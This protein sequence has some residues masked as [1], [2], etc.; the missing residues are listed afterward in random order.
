[1]P[2]QS[3]K[4]EYN[5]FVKGLITEA[6]P[7]NFPENASQDE[8]NFDLHRTGTRSRR[9]GMAY[10]PGYSLVNSLVTANSVRA[11][12]PTTFQW[13]NTGGD[14]GLTILV[15]QFENNLNFFNQQ[16]EPLA[17]SGYLATITLSGFPS[18]VQYSFTSVDGTLVVAAGIDTIC[19]VNYTGSAFVSSYERIAVRDV[20]GIEEVNEPSYETDSS[21]RGGIDSYHYYNLQNQ[22]WGIPRKRF[23]GVVVD[24]AWSYFADGGKGVWP[25]NS[26]AVW[27]GLQFKPIE[28]SA[29]PYEHLFPRLF[30]DVFGAKVVSAKG[31]YIIDLLRRGTSRV[32][33]LE[34]NYTKFPEL[35]YNSIS[36]PADYTSG[37]AT[38][39][40]DFAGRVFYGGFNGV[41]TDGD[42]RSPNL[43]NY[44]FFSQLIKNKKDFTKCYQEGDPTSRDSS[45]LVDTDGGFVR[46]SGMDRLIGMVSLSTHLIVIANN[47]VWAISGGSDFGFTPTNYKV[48]KLS[49]FGGVGRFSI[50]ENLGRALFWGEDGIF[51]VAK[52]QFGEF[53]VASITE[54]TIQT[55]YDSIDSKAKQE[56]VGVYDAFGKK[57]RWIYKLNDAFTASS[58]TWELVLDT[59]LNAFYKQRIYNSPN[60]TTEVFSV[61][62]TLGIKTDG[63]VNNILSGTD[64]VVSGFSE[65]VTPNT[66]R[67]TGIQKV[68]YLAI[69]NTAI[70]TSF[71]FSYYRD[72]DFKDWPHDMGGTDAFAFLLTGQTTGGDSSLPKQIPYVTLH[73]YRTE[74]GV[75]DGLIPD[76]QSSCLMRFRWEW[77]DTSNSHKWSRIQESYRYRLPRFIEGPSDDYDTGFELVST[78]NKIR[79]RGKAFCMY[80]ETSPNKDCKIV[81]W[82]LTAN[83]NVV[84]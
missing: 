68:R 12:K 63:S 7:L 23:D 34:N 14:T 71:A 82:N 16:S 72:E 52:N 36:A 75:T 61:I 21:Y 80:L 58:Q 84:T 59:V 78:K 29:E 70:T 11:V 45:D 22:S 65:V 6:S 50:V 53:N 42:A 10:E 24:P 76:N 41:V 4:A 64:N 40:A 46:I 38:V 37:G 44:I 48:D 32:S 57:I 47:G 49:T 43:N 62:P 13:K 2:K 35:I 30:N 26:E 74:S 5:V 33:E 55:Y 39:V 9:L 66:D 81:G 19:L 83:S 60:N 20:W 79:G 8:Q 15:V 27:A 56:V 18:D 73:F 51:V 3:A 31:Y 25:S 17:T 67:I 1:M 77:S 28:G 54:T 69:E